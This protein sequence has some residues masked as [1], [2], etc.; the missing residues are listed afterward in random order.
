MTYEDKAPYASS[1]PC[2]VNLG[3]YFYSAVEIQ[4][5]TYQHGVATIRRLLNM[6]GLFF[7]RAL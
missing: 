3:R 4:D 5:A 1:S 7:K 2:K 6:I